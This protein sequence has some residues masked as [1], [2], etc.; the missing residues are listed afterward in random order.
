MNFKDGFFKD[1]QDHK[2]SLVKKIREYRPDIVITNAPSDRHPDH[3]RSSQ[4]T[5]DACFLSGLEK[6][7]TNQQI[8]RPKNIFIIQYMTLLQI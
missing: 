8:W 6:I 2:L 1:D 7:N 4:I 5:V 3:P